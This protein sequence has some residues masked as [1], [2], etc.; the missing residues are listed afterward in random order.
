MEDSLDEVPEELMAML[1]NV[2]FLVEDGA[3]ERTSRTCSGVYDGVAAHRAGLRAGAW[4]TCPTGSPCS[5]GR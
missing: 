5:E 2:V 3:A 4:A 1:D